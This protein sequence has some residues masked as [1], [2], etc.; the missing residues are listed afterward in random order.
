MVS[1]LCAKSKRGTRLLLV[2]LKLTLPVLRLLLHCRKKR[3]NAAANFLPLGD[4]E[5]PLA[6]QG[7]S[8]T[9]LRLAPPFRV[10]AAVL[11]HLPESLIMFAQLPLPLRPFTLLSL[12]PPFHTFLLLP[13]FFLASPYL[14]FD[15]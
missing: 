6:L 7:R 5:D 9:R 13:P 11:Y 3:R 12:A 15:P 10:A 2:R 1:W 14:P 4:D 8:G